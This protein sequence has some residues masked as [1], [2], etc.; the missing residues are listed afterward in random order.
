MVNGLPSKQ[1]IWVQFSLPVSYIMMSKETGINYFQK[2]ALYF[3]KKGKKSILESKIRVYL[4]EVKQKK[5]KLLVNSTRCVQNVRPYVRLLVRKRG[6]R[7]KY[8]VGFIEREKAE[9]KAFLS[10]SKLLKDNKTGNF[11]SVLD[12]EIENI[13][14]GKNN[15]VTKKNLL[16]KTA[17]QFAPF[18]WRKKTLRVVK[19]IKRNK[20]W[21]NEGEKYLF[22]IKQRK[23]KR[24]KSK[25]VKNKN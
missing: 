11:L 6:K 22:K 5:Q 21:K 17:W 7:L 3:L 8:K 10:I 14:L 12:K 9:K 1:S 13:A 4:K 25:K 16:H 15:L 23:Y 18:K 24:L 2:L 19:N 20:K